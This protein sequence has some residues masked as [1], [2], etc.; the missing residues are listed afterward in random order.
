MLRSREKLSRYL[1]LVLDDCDHSGSWKQWEDGLCLKNPTYT[2]K[3][4]KQTQNKQTC[5]RH[6]FLAG[7][8]L[9]CPLLHLFGHSIFLGEFLICYPSIHL[10]SH[11]WSS[12]SIALS[13]WKIIMDRQERKNENRI[14]LIGK[15]WRFFKTSGALGWWGE[16]GGVSPCGSWIKPALV[17]LG[18]LTDPG[19]GNLIIVFLVFMLCF[20][21]SLFSWF[22]PVTVW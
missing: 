22:Q 18:W 16:V 6:T 14:I 20:L 9:W 1:G 13:H 17:R 4:N 15:R 10:I 8:E 11:L 21:Q 5:V 2:W 7:A 12:R 19:A 3:K